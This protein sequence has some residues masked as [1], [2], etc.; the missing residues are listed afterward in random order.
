MTLENNFLIVKR[1]LCSANEV[2]KAKDKQ[3]LKLIDKNDELQLS[4][5]TTAQGQ[6]IQI[7]IMTDT[8]LRLNDQSSLYLDKIESLKLKV[9]NGHN[10]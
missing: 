5:E 10:S 8:I 6:A 1:S 2:I 9:A 4:I 3:I 7:K